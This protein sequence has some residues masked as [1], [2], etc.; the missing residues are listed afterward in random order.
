MDFLKTKPVMAMKSGGFQNTF[1]ADLLERRPQ[2]ETLELFNQWVAMVQTQLITVKARKNCPLAWVG[3]FIDEHGIVLITQFT[4]GLQICNA[5]ATA[6]L[7]VNFLGEQMRDRAMSNMR[8]LDELDYRRINAWLTPTSCCPVTT[9]MET[10]EYTDPLVEADITF[11]GRDVA[12]KTPKLSEFQC[13]L[14]AGCTYTST[15]PPK[16]GLK[17]QRPDDSL[18]SDAPPP[19]KPRQQQLLDYAQHLAESDDDQEEDTR[20]VSQLHTQLRIKNENDRCTIESVGCTLGAIEDGVPT[21]SAPKNVVHASVELKDIAGMPGDQLLANPQLLW[22]FRTIEKATIVVVEVG[23]RP[24]LN[25]V[26]CLQ[27]TRRVMLLTH[28]V[29]EKYDKFSMVAVMRVAA[30]LANAGAIPSHVGGPKATR[31]DFVKRCAAA[32]KALD[33]NAECDLTKLDATDQS[34]IRAFLGGKEEPYNGCFVESC[35]DKKPRWIEKSYQCASEMYSTML[36]V[37]CGYCDM[38]KNYG[39]TWRKEPSEFARA[40]MES[41]ASDVWHIANAGYTRS[42]LPPIKDWTAPE[43]DDDD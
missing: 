14:I 16:F 15:L 20:P 36:V 35:L 3:I 32:L 43:S 8:Q 5:K 31:S 22:M 7:L 4:R 23:N 30:G 26:K 1:I 41:S 34:S 25:Y 17:R 39:R 29:R 37:R 24:V 40:R 18:D 9:K 42:K 38:P 11:V 10:E 19:K 13:G 27:E 21:S 12:D 28:A 2:L 33:E 6:R